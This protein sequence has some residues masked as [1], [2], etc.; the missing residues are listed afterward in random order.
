MS[1]DNSLPPASNF[2]ARARELFGNFATL[3]I[4]GVGHLDVPVEQYA[5]G[6]RDELLV[7]FRHPITHALH[8]D[9]IA[10]EGDE[11]FMPTGQQ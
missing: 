7:L 10:L 9:G 2:A 1:T 11:D 8:V 3:H 6:E 5:I 4:R